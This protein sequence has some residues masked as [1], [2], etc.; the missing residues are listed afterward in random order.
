MM[1]RRNVEQLEEKIKQLGL[2]FEKFNLEIKVNIDVCISMY[3]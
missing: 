1:H 3:V 2:N